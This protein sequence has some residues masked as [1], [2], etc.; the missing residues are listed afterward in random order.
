MSEPHQNTDIAASLERLLPVLWDTYFTP[1]P[2]GLVVDL[3]VGQARTLIH[4]AVAGRRRMGELADDLGV[5]LPTA[6]RIVDRLVERDLVTRESWDKDRRVVW[7]QATEEGMAIAEAAR[8][9]RRG[10]IV[11]R[12]S[13]LD[14]RQRASI[15]RAL[16]LLE[17]VVAE[18]ARAPS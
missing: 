14:E 13:K 10:I 3:P 16:A 2:P 4:L 15:V 9:F 12:L 6:T 1:L 5:K 17:E 18:P 7:V 11:R 8:Q